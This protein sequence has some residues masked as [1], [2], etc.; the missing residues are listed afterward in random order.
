MSINSSTS[1]KLPGLIL[2]IFLTF[3]MLR[4]FKR[5]KNTPFQEAA[6]PFSDRQYAPNRVGTGFLAMDE[7]V[8]TIGKRLEA[9]GLTNTLATRTAYRDML[10]TTDF[11]GLISCVILHPETIH[12]CV[13]ST[14]LL[15]IPHL[16]SLNIQVAIKLDE[17]L[18]PFN[19]HEYVT[20]WHDHMQPKIYNYVAHGAVFFKWR[21]LFTVSEEGQ[22]SLECVEE[23][24]RNALVFLKATI[25]V[26]A[27]P[28]LEPELHL[29]GSFS[30]GYMHRVTTGL[31]A[32]LR[33]LLVSHYLDKKVILKVG[34]ITQGL[35]CG[36]LP[37]ED[38]G[39]LS[40][41]FFHYFY[42][43]PMIL[44]LSGGLPPDIATDYLTH[45]CRQVGHYKQEYIHRPF[46][47]F[48]FG[49][50]L[51]EDC[52]QTWVKQPALAQST[53]LSAIERNVGALWPQYHASDM[54]EH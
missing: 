26:R 30:Q 27:T 16:H 31:F 49:R 3:I 25:A 8:P 41:F 54:S 34:F 32:R 24:F 39:M 35:Q 33:F 18:S 36:Y 20:L 29:E 13:S 9:V 2:C 17:G 5:K 10:L 15:A 44:F 7:S 46:I 28:I 37:A 45:T 1:I 38:V 4:F 12:H 51:Q 43:T 21:M 47:S 14:Q 19:Q 11:R 42:T 48:S 22:P 52:L 40:A 6:M 23:N 53:L 50:G